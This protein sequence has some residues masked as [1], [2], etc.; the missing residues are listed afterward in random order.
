MTHEQ[1][2]PLT[3]WLLWP[4]FADGARLVK[5]YP[6]ASTQILSQGFQSAADPEISFDASQLLFSAKRTADDDWNI[7]E[8]QTDGSGIRQVTHGIG[9]CRS[10]G[11]QATLYTIVSPKPW[12]QL[13]FVGSE[14]GALNE[15]GDGIA[16]SLYSCKLDGSAVRRLTFNL[17]SDRD[18]FIMPDGRL[19]FA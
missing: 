11:Y 2:G 17:S 5:V 8:M 19:L 15:S 4:E 12:Y 3:P 13:T 1:H 16:T 14:K 18:P 6:D 10:P 9:N 7:Y